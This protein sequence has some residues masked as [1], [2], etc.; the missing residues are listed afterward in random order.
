MYKRQV[1]WWTNIDELAREVSE[2]LHQ[3]MDRK[4]RPGWIRGVA[5]ATFS[6]EHPANDAAAKSAAAS[7]I[8]PFIVIPFTGPARNYLSSF[9]TK[10]RKKYTE[11][12]TGNDH[13]KTL[14]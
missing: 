12:Y 3:Q 9:F 1:Q 4:K 11:L 7:F 8:H 5:T 14:F 10:S 13:D 6:S 2:S